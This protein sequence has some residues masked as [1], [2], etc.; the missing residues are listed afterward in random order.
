MKTLLSKSSLM[1]REDLDKTL[2]SFCGTQ[3]STRKTRFFLP[4][5]K[6][7]TKFSLCLI[8]LFVRL[9]ISS[10]PILNSYPSNKNIYF[11]SGNSLMV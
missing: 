1:L 10:D 2:E 3:T 8:S 11:A 6:I 5:S 9:I 7:F 4:K